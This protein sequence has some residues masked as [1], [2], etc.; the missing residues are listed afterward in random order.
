M[1]A[2][3]LMHAGVS[4]A[5]LK[6]WMR[7]YIL[8]NTISGARAERHVGSRS[9]K[10]SAMEDIQAMKENNVLN[11]TSSPLREDQ[12]HMFLLK[13]HPGFSSSPVTMARS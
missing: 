4:P 3:D 12:V 5:W 11:G 7:W 9:Q 6:R 8:G 2:R 13:P 1:R 10:K